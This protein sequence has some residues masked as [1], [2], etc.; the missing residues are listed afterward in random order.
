MS[1]ATQFA[2]F[3]VQARKV[4][5]L[6]LPYFQ[7]EQ[8]WKARLLLAAV[9]ALNLAYVYVSVQ[10]NEWYRVFY[11]ALQ[12]KD[13]A[14]FWAQIRWFCVIA[15][16]N[17]VIQVYRLYLRQKLELN[18]RAWMTSY[19]LKRW[20][21]N[22]AFYHLELARYTVAQDASSATPDNPDQRI[23]EDA[24]LFTEYTV[25]LTM[26]FLLAVV[27]IAAFIGILWGLSG[28]FEFT[29]GGQTYVVAGFLVWLAIL[30][31][32]AGSI[33]TH[34]IGKPLVGLNFEQQ[35][36]EANFR[37]DLVRVRE[38]SEPIALS[39]GETVECHALQTRFV[40]VVENTLRMMLAQ[41]RLTWFTAGYGQ[42]AVIFPYI[43]AAPRYF[44]GAIQLGGLM[45]IG[46]AFSEVQGSMSWL[47]DNYANLAKWKAT[48]DRLTSFEASL[49]T[50]EAQQLQQNSA[51]SQ[52]NVAQEAI[53]NAAV[54]NHLALNEL[55]L[56]LPNGTS[57]AS[58]VS[59]SAHPGDSIIVSGPSG[60]GKSTLFRTIAGIWPFSNLGS[61]GR[62]TLPADFAQQAMFIPQRPYFPNASLRAA[63]AY[64]DEASTYNDDALRAALDAALL[65]H[66]KERLND[67][68]AW[69]QKLSGGEQQRLAIARVFLK[70][71]RW[72]FA[73]E[74]TSALD[75]AAEKTIYERLLAQVKQTQGALVSIA[76]RP[77]VAAFHASAWR[78]EPTA[79]GAQALFSVLARP[80]V[81]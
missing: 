60:S 48:T 78:F 13:Q 28:G 64:P 73:D 80:G 55:T 46:S 5:A 3:K 43:V 33:F 81:K 59:L 74:A 50:V 57:L 26:G 47:V 52:L 36:R 62:I 1:I 56:S 14:V 38:Y 17:I 41:K 22:K 24:K 45:Q 69:S 37:H 7:S 72:V 53:E 27:N 77:T 25:T 34:F 23:Q 54:D 8:K 15:F 66:L 39:K 58:H 61:S 20:T 71:P 19:Y 16:F 51:V 35:K 42:A 2:S 10:F 31:A 29:S 32:A 40:S 70:K 68:D 76:H 63:L 44:G 21:Q 12:N 79:A 49:S 30:Y 18:W 75:E 4:W 6:S 9:M 11:D 65:P 67:E